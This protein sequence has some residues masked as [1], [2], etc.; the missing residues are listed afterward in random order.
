[1]NTYNQKM[2]VIISAG[3]M[4]AHAVPPVP[5][6]LAVAE[7][8]LV[9]QDY[10]GAEEV[11]GRRLQSAPEDNYALYLR[12]AIAQT[13]LL[14]YESYALD[15]VRFLALADS[16]RKVLEGRLCRLSGQD[17][18]KCLLYIANIYGGMSVIKAKTGSWFSALKSSL[19]SAGM[20]KEVAER[21]STMYAALLGRGVFHYYLRRSF[22]WLPF[23]SA[24]GD[25]E[26]VGE[27]EKATRSSFPY[28]FAARNT[29]CW[30]L[31]DKK[32]YVRADSVAIAALDEAPESTI[33][34]RIRCLIALWSRQY[35][36]A[37]VLAQKLSAISL[38]RNPVNWSDYVMSYYV[39][40]G[41]YGGL[42]KV[43]EALAA[44]EHILGA[45]IPPEFK[46]IPPVKKNLKR[47]LAIK[48]KY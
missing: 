44:A 27:V 39:L 47:I 33:F 35:D 3:V 41:G 6:S 28:R 12:V 30:I 43:K 42:G 17:S 5:S 23:V 7:T 48:E 8:L 34:M 11:V 16:V 15:G 22:A 10:A 31:I 4:A 14:D 19:T 21:D 36:R 32:Q 1:M 45:T 25:N 37:L 2:V 24:G 46:K 9:T 13:E 20:L 29:L 40:A 18:T 38:R 26:G